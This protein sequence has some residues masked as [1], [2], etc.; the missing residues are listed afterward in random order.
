MGSKDPSKTRDELKCTGSVNSTNTT[1]GTDRVTNFNGQ[2]TVHEVI[3]DRLKQI[4]SH[5]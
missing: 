3:G 1:R 4:L 5:L 2:G